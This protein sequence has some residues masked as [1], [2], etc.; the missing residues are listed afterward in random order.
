MSLESMKKTVTQLGAKTVLERERAAE[1]LRKT[2]SG[3]L[4]VVPDFLEAAQIA[5]ERIYKQGV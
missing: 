5:R 3:V 1:R 2:L 4:A